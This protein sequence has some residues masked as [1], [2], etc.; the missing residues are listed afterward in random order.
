[1]EESISQSDYEEEINEKELIDGID[2]IDN[3][4]IILG[5]EDENNFYN[6]YNIRKNKSS[7]ILTKYEKTKILYERVNHLSLGSKPY[8]NSKNYT[9]LYKIAL[10]ELNQKKLPYIIKRNIGDK[11]EYWKLSDLLIL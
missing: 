3:P 5:D 4:S 9:D 7:N 2:E 8:I 1:M 6:T 10:E 11:N